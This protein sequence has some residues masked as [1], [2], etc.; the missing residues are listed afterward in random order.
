MGCTTSNSVECRPSSSSVTCMCFFLLL[1]C[2]VVSTV[3]S[4]QNAQHG[5][6]MFLVSVVDLSNCIL[7]MVTYHICLHFFFSLYLFVW[8]KRPSKLHLRGGSWERSKSHP[9]PPLSMAFY[10]PYKTV[11]YAALRSDARLL[12]VNSHAIPSIII[13][14]TEYLIHRY[15]Q[16]KL[17]CIRNGT[18]WV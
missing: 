15:A 8:R 4:D 11:T 7:Y 16:M 1:R 14:H 10:C 6:N 5:N 12:L 17:Q 18:A 9:D 3:D 13:H 2:A